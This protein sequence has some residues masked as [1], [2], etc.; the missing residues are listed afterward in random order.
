MRQLCPIRWN[1]SLGNA[2]PCMMASGTWEWFAYLLG[3]GS[4]DLVRS[5]IIRKVWEILGVT[6]SCR[7]LKVTWTMWNLTSDDRWDFWKWWEPGMIQPGL[8][9]HFSRFSW[10]FP[11][12]SYS[13]SVWCQDS[14]R[15]CGLQSHIR[16]ISGICGTLWRVKKHY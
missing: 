14:Y 11:P 15:D 9:L 3:G 1:S 16:M 2:K 10:L 4:R 8:S 6:S 13:S 7:K 12:L 5:W